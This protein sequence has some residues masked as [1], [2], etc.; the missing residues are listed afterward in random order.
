MEIWSG[1]F[2]SSPYCSHHYK[3]DMN[4]IFFDVEWSDGEISGADIR[5]LRYNVSFDAYCKRHK[6]S[7]KLVDR[8]V[9]IVNDRDNSEE[10]SR[11]TDSVGL[12]RNRW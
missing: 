12:F 6:I 8:Q 5:D 7:K 11:S 3:K 9:A 10:P 1:L 4:E 2:R